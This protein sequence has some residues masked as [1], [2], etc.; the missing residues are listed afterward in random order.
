MSKP[1]ML[2]DEDD[3][4]ITRLKKQLKVHTKIEVVR[5]GLRLL[6]KKMMK[7][8]RMAQWKEA[9]HLVRKTSHDVL[10]DFQKYSRLKRS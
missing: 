2:Q 10:Q 7:E 9:A 3:Q 6:Q 4:T 5:I 1:M 8:R